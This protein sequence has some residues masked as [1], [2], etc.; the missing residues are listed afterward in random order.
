[1]N[2]IA[3]LFGIIAITLWVFS[4]QKNNKKDILFF[5]T[6]ANVFYIILYIILGAYSGAFMNTISAS[7][8]LIYYEYEKQNKKIPKYWPLIFLIII[9]ILGIITLDGILSLIPTLIAAAYIIS[10]WQKN[11]K[12]I[13]IVYILAAIAWIYY[14]FMVGAYICILGNILE[15]TSGITA[16]IRHRKITK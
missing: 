9:T 7:K 12:I 10:T 13:R 6:G 4:I 15:I 5:Q 16:L 8:G 2:I 11:L 3:Q 1:M 14:N